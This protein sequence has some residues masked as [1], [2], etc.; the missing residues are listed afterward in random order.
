MLKIFFFYK[1]QED[2][3]VDDAADEDDLEK[4]EPPLL[5]MSWTEDQQKLQ[6]I[7]RYIFVINILFNITLFVGCLVGIML[8]LNS[9]KR[10]LECTLVKW[11]YY[12]S[13]PESKG[14]FGYLFHEIPGIKKF[15]LI[16][17]PFKAY[18]RIPGLFLK[19]YFYYDNI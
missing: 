3:A 2:E 18:H 7:G 17:V 8:Q 9:Y 6:T 4:I 15:T 10:Y 11:S 14:S 1:E 19:R 13:F 12:L 16:Q 5:D